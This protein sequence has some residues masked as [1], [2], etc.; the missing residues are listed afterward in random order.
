MG[1]WMYEPSNDAMFSIA[2]ISQTM[3]PSGDSYQLACPS[4][5]PNA[6]CAFQSYSM[7][8]VSPADYTVLVHMSFCSSMIFS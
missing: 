5:C 1:I 6:K 7:P 4:L 2:A 3:P 8:D